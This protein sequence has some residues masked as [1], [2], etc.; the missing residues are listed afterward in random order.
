MWRQTRKACVIYTSQDVLDE[1]E[2]K[3]RLK[4]GFH[5]RHAHLM[6]SFVR[7]Q[8]TQA[9]TT[10]PLPDACRDPDDN[11]ILAAAMNVR[12]AYLVTGDNDLLS[13]REFEDIQI[14]RPREFLELIPRIKSGS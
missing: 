13:L 12:C 9:E 8:T 14:V 10:F 7:R 1:I 6:I 5:A 11:K 3:L 2:E 4:F